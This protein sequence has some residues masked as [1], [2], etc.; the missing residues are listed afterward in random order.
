MNTVLTDLAETVQ[1][2][3]RT[4]TTD[5]LL[6]SAAGALIE[7]AREWEAD[8]LTVGSHGFSGIERW[9]LGSVSEGVLQRSPCSVLVVREPQTPEAN[10]VT[11]DVVLAPVT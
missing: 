6:G 5:T 4:I 10:P 8:L 11:S 2:P 1:N 9:L 7:T 3:A